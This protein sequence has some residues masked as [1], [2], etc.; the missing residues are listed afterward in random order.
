MDMKSIEKQKEN[1]NEFNKMY[2]YGFALVESL[3]ACIAGIFFN[4][5]KLGCCIV[6]LNPYND[7]LSNKMNWKEEERGIFI[8]IK[9]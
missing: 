5:V 1:N 7:A 4:I 3:S 9:K 6:C 2:V 8:I